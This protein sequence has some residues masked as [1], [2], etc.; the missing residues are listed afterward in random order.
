MCGGGRIL[1]D[2]VLFE[3][4]LEEWRSDLN[5]TL[6]KQEL[7]EG[8]P[9]PNTNH[10]YSFIWRDLANLYL[11]KLLYSEKKV[12]QVWEDP[13]FTVLNSFFDIWMFIDNQVW[14][15]NHLPPPGAWAGVIRL[16]LSKTESIQE[17]RNLA[18]CVDQGGLPLRL[19][20]R[21][22]A[23]SSIYCAF[24]MCQMLW[25]QLWA[26]PPAVSIATVFKYLKGF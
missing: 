8:T 26:K 11:C 20:E 4:N 7:R 14:L 21:G 23:F 24:I 2:S 9:H 17:L 25:T 5:Q 3:S 19:W 15:Y 6:N 16:S 18:S 13:E 1:P 22:S 10:G 12:E